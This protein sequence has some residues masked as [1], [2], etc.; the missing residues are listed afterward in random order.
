MP[1]TNYYPPLSSYI[2]TEKLPCELSFIN[3]F[4]DKLYL[5]SYKCN[6]NESGNYDVIRACIRTK[7]AISKDLL[8]GNCKL[9]F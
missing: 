3:E 9:G 6:T 1:S 7:T 2:N 8:N 5:R 4:L